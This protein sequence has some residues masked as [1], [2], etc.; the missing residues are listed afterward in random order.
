MQTVESYF[1]DGVCGA[2][3]WPW[4]WTPLAALLLYI[5]FKNNGLGKGLLTMVVLALAAS[6]A[7]ELAILVGKLFPQP[8]DEGTLH[9]AYAFALVV[10]LGLEVR[11]VT[12]T[13]VNVCWACLLVAAHLYLGVTQPVLLALDAAVGCA[14][15]AACSYLLLQY[16]QRL[17]HAPSYISSQY[18]TGGYEVEDIRWYSTLFL[19]IGLYLVFMGILTPCFDIF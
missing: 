12:L 14:V 16:K 10:F 7:G 11:S 18:T 9:T 6:V 2:A 5:L 1:L 8:A 4:T 15:G 17:S 13:L 3:L 19:L